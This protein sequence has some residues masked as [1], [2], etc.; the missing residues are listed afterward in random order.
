[1]SVAGFKRSSKDDFLVQYEVFQCGWR[2]AGCVGADCCAAIV[3]VVLV[4]LV[5]L[6]VLTFSCVDCVN[7]F[8]L[9]W[10]P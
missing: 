5:V 1:M 10:L 2:A 4:V 7:F 9:L 3:L 8:C 6:T